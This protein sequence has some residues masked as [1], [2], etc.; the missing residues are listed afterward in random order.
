MSNR[1]KGNKHVIVTFSVF[2]HFLLLT[3]SQSVHALY[4]FTFLFYFEGKFCTSC[5]CFFSPSFLIVSPVCIYCLFVFSITLVF[6]LPFEAGFGVFLY[7]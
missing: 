3:A 4:G 2:M 7:Y 1:Q 6:L 5:C